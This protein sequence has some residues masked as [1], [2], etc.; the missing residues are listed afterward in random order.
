MTIYVSQLKY[1]SGLE[2]TKCPN[3]G[4]Y[5]YGGHLTAWA[6]YWAGVGG[7]DKRRPICE[8]VIIN[9]VEEVY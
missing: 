6:K 1:E 8:T 7:T 9:K 5:F 3:T 4:P 2:I